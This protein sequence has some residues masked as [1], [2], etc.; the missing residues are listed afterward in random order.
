VERIS[1]DRG[2]NYAEGASL[3][4]PHA[5][6]ATDRWHLLK[7]LGETLESFFLSQNTLLKA[8]LHS[9][10]VLVG[11]IV[12]VLPW[13]TGGTTRLEGVSRA[14]HQKQVERSEQIHALAASQVPVASI[15]RQLGASRQT[16]YTELRRTHELRNEVVEELPPAFVGDS[17]IARGSVRLK[18][19]RSRGRGRET[20]SRSAEE[21][22]KRK[23][24][25]CGATRST[26][27]ARGAGNAEAATARF[28]P[29]LDRARSRGQLEHRT[30]G[31]PLGQPWGRGHCVP[32]ARPTRGGNAPARPEK[33]GR[34]GVRA[35]SASRFDLHFEALVTQQLQAGAARRPPVPVTPEQGGDADAERMQEQAHLTRF[36]GGS[37]VLL[38]RLP[39]RAGATTAEAGPIHPNSRIW[40]GAG[41]RSS[42]LCR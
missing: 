41:R 7:N 20:S 11:S 10:E 5:K 3:G 33:G 8:A 18:L 29:S 36:G 31:S 26:R 17:G 30:G 12:P 9:P 23:K 1:R 24:K 14:H 2:G 16:V 19:S 37:A 34:R 35:G 38:T 28:T 15:A 39:Q 4:A 6:Q 22:K 13:H 27:R 25:P 40:A 21:Q 42:R 32:A